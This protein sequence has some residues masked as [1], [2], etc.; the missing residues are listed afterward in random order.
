MDA[1]H[2]RWMLCLCSVKNFLEPTSYIL[3]S[4]AMSNPDTYEMLPR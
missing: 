2:P 1:L 3:S 4:V